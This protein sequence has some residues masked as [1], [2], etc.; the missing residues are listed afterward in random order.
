[1]NFSNIDFSFKSLIYDES[2]CVSYAK[3]IQKTEKIPDNFGQVKKISR[4]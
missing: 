3:E 1:M 2:F 4:N